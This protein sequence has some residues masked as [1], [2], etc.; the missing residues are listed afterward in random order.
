MS[1][2]FNNIMAIHGL[3]VDSSNYHYDSNV[4]QMQFPF[5][6]DVNFTNWL[7]QWKEIQVKVTI[8]DENGL[9]ISSDNT[10]KT[11][12]RESENRGESAE[13]S[14]YENR[15]GNYF[16]CDTDDD[17]GR[18]S[19]IGISKTI[20]TFK[21]IRSITIECRDVDNNTRSASRTYEKF[22]NQITYWAKGTDGGFVCDYYSQGEACVMPIYTTK[23]CKISELEKIDV[24]GCL[25]SDGDTGIRY[26]N[27]KYYSKQIAI[28]C[29]Y[30]TYYD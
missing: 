6:R 22:C 10:W 26:F 19:I 28:K 29:P 1:S 16:V 7:V 30:I 3:S 27:K 4:L 2:S 12:V 23:K 17:Y 24:Q 20:T 5:F 14:V 13:E 21:N 9:I 11:I 18:H 25:F 8:K 15:N